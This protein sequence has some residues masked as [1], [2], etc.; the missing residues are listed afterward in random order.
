MDHNEFKQLFGQFKEELAKGIYAT[1]RVRPWAM[2]AIAQN[3]PE[4]DGITGILVGTDENFSKELMP[5]GRYS[6][7]NVSIDYT[8]I[9]RWQ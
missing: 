3:T 1:N 7:P 5:K 8:A 6:E 4:K 2:W 9:G